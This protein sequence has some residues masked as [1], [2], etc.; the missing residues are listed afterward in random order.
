[1]TSPFLNYSGKHLPEFAE[2]AAHSL[3]A[4][5]DD[6][7]QCN[8]LNR[9][10]AHRLMAKAWYRLIGPVRGRYERDARPCPDPSISV[11]RP[12]RYFGSVSE[13][14]TSDLEVYVA[15][16]PDG[17]LRESGGDDDEDDDESGPLVK[18]KFESMMQLIYVRSLAEPG[19]SVGLLASQSIG[20]PST[21][22][23]L[24]TFH[25][26]GRGEM[27]VTLGIPR[28]REIL[29]V[30]SACIKT[31]S[32]EIPFRR[33]S[34]GG[35]DRKLLVTER[36]SSVSLSQVLEKVEVWESSTL[37]GGEKRRQRR[38]RIRTSSDVDN[39]LAVSSEEILQYVER[40]F[41]KTLVKAVQKHVVIQE[42]RRLSAIHESRDNERV[43]TKDGEE[44]GGDDDADSS[45]D[46]DI[47]DDADA[48][49]SKKRQQSRQIATYDE[50]DEEDKTAIRMQEEESDNSETEST[51]DKSHSPPQKRQFAEGNSPEDSDGDASDG[52]WIPSA[53]T[54]K[55]KEVRKE[56]VQKFSPNIVDYRFD[57]KKGNWFE[58]TLQFQ[59][60]SS[61]VMMV[62]LVEKLAK[63]AIVYEVPGIKRCFVREADNEVRLTTEGVNIQ[64]IWQFGDVLDVD[65][66]YSN[67]IHAV[68]KTYGIEAARRLLIKEVESVFKVYGIEVDPRHLSLIADYMTFSGVYRAFNRLG[69][70]T[71]T[72]PFQKMSFETSIHFLKNVTLSGE[73]DRLESPSSC[74]VC[75][76]VVNVGTGC[77]ELLY[78]LSV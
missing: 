1:M 63:R 30:A 22:M 57:G 62:S 31:P 52:E 34:D 74:L 41:V 70:E 14:L 68:A 16:N 53:D 10:K 19:E 48:S 78:S 5:D 60:R 65:R 77:C 2:M 28:L 42:K 15:R 27:N 66:L 39:R 32:M 49:Q 43:K 20:E 3:V 9:S 18:G 51:T 33:D 45:S 40:T 73:V 71:N 55:Q 11:Y 47:G 21:Q 37:A 35:G 6:N 7:D 4:D 72:S 29:M 61:K 76:R 64:E 59:L 12:D 23:T 44:A 56:A 67:D 36:L 46:V 58:I 26:A 75:G 54:A 38:Y 25:F 13:K 24:N 8:V 50:P 17:L 69:F